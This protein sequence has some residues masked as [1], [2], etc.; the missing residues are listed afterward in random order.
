MLAVVDNKKPRKKAAFFCSY[1]GPGK[2]TVFFTG[3]SFALRQIAGIKESLKGKYKKLYFAARPA[4]LTFESFNDGY[5]RY[6]QCDEIRN[7][8]VQF[9]EKFRPDFLIIT[10]K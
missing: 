9:L 4:C 8:T 10:E 2:A 3:N 5:E 7:K 1:D 6:W